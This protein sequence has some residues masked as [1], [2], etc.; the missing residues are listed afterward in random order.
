M[1]TLCTYIHIHSH[2]RYNLFT[3]PKFERS[4]GHTKPNQPTPSHFEQSHNLVAES[5]VRQKAMT[6][7]SSC[8]IQTGLP[9]PYL[10]TAGHVEQKTAVDIQQE[11]Q[12]VLNRSIPVCRCL[13]FVQ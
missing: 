7:D 4:C 2:R 12:R 6:N 10:I 1:C 5:L 3:C 8:L 11:R 13:R 9:E